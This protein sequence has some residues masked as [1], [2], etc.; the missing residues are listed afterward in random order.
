MEKVE[1][2]QL[3]IFILVTYGVTFVQGL[4]MWFFYEKGAD[5]SIFP[6]TQMFYPAGGGSCWHIL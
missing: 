5:L 3:I 4:L 2:K 1:K 6:E